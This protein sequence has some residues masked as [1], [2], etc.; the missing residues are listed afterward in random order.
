MLRIDNL[1]K[2][3]NGRTIFQAVNCEVSAG[4]VLVITGPNGSGKSTLLKI[5]CGLLN[6]TRGEVRWSIAGHEGS[7]KESMKK[8]GY[9]SPEMGL[10]DRLTAAEQDRKSVV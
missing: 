6:P 10:Y 5:L 4:Q 9:L 2:K 3:Y 7:P 1:S 8:L